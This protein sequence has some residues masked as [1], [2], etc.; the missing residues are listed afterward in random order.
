MKNKSVT[1]RNARPVRS[2][3][4]IQNRRPASQT[5][6]KNGKVTIP[7]L[8]WNSNR[9]VGLGILPVSKKN[10]QVRQNKENQ[11]QTRRDYRSGSRVRYQRS[12]H[13]SGIADLLKQSGEGAEDFDFKVKLSKDFAGFLSLHLNFNVRFSFEFKEN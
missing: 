8:K 11:V 12:M 5:R 13:G 1:A 3:R 7:H 4:S 9:S 2:N 6:S 10:A